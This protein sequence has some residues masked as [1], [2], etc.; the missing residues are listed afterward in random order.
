MSEENIQN[1]V[2]E[3]MAILGDEGRVKAWLVNNEKERK[4]KSVIELVGPFSA[5]GCSARDPERLE[6]LRT[7]IM[8]ADNLID[9]IYEESKQRERSEQSLEMSGREA[10]GYLLALKESLEDVQ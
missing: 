5:L 6:N 3:L 4:K 1:Q 9:G 8:I 2:A 10:H 7:A